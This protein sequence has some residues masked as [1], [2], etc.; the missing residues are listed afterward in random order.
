MKKLVGKNVGVDKRLAARFLCTL[1]AGRYR[2]SAC[3]TDAAGNPQ[4]RVASNRLTV[5]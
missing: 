2:F 4:A 1:P 3:A 5:R